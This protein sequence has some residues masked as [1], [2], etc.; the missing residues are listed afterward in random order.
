MDGDI[1]NCI[2]TTGEAN[3]VANEKKKSVWFWTLWDSG[4]Y[5]PSSGNGDTVR[6]L[7]KCSGLTL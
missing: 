4:I 7:R 5:S 1:I 6:H 3:L 2:E